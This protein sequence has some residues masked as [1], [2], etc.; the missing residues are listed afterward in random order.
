MLQASE[1]TWTLVRTLSNGLC[2]AWI[3]GECKRGREKI[4]RK[5]RA[6]ESDGT[7]PRSHTQTSKPDTKQ[8]QLMS[9][10]WNHWIYFG[11]LKYLVLDEV[12]FHFYLNRLRMSLHIKFLQPHKLVH[13]S[14]SSSVKPTLRPFIFF[15]SA[16]ILSFCG[17]SK[18][19]CSYFNDL[20]L[21]C[22]NMPK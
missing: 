15:N 17:C 9:C 10:L 5:K 12:S 18:R 2:M 22:G 16:L 14:W 11:P 3:F 19:S 6:Y 20:S 1:G 4:N 13:R 7:C 8:S 21:A